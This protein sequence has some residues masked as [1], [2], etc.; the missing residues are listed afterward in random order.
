MGMTMN[1]IQLRLAGVALAA[2]A[3]TGCLDGVGDEREIETAD[4]LIAAHVEARG[5][6]AAWDSIYTITRVGRYSESSFSEV[7]RFD[8]R[9][10]N[11]LRI[12]TSYDA[13]T[14]E[15]GYSE[16]FDG[17]AWEYRGGVP[18]RVVGEPSRALRN[19]SRFE[20]PY[21]DYRAKNLQA[22]LVG[23]TSIKGNQVYHLVITHPDGE[24]ENFFFDV[25]SLLETVSIGRAPFHGEGKEIEIF[26]KRSDYRRVGGV[27][28][29]FRTEQMSGDTVLASLV[30]ET[31]EVNRDVPDG[32]FS[33]PP[34]TRQAAFIEFRHEV[35]SGGLDELDSDYADYRQSADAQLDQQLENELNTFGYE[36]ISHER[37]EDAIGVFQLAI[38]QHPTSA[39]LHD[40]LG[41][42]YL[43][44]ADTAR[45]VIHYRKSLELNPNN[46]HAADVLARIAEQASTAG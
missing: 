41:E 29:P 36:L 2:I 15:Y 10:P 38:Q 8:R 17:G 21:I 28:L 45:S 37:Y 31:I 1:L 43:L 22:E 18:E 5:G 35:L 33:P 46:G 42:A 39:N 25:D 4:D 9:R 19:A 11:L 34:S 30:W 32:W 20:P 40:S 23:E 44:D 27:L 26:E 16:G 24:T 7:H 12:T 3:I 13:D 14:G 6:K